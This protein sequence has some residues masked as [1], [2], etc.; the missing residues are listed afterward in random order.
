MMVKFETTKPAGDNF[1]QQ[2][3]KFDDFIHCYNKERPHQAL[4]I[5]Y[6]AERYVLSTRPLCLRGQRSGRKRFG[7]KATRWRNLSRSLVRPFFRQTST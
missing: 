4:N 7:D 2:Q 5:R 1:L 3:A 6:P